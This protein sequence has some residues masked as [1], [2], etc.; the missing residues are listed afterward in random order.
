MI[1]LVF[2][3]AACQPV[4]PTAAPATKLTFTYWG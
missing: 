2:G 1:A 3:L 4:P